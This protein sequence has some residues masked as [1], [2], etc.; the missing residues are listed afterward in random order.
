MRAI[1]PKSSLDVYS[2]VDDAE[3][4]TALPPIHIQSLP[5]SPNRTYLGIPPPPHRTFSPR[6]SISQF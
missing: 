3:L 1:L 6:F 5:H 2:A 4:F